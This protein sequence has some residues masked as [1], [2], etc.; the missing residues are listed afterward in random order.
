MDRFHSNVSRFVWNMAI[1]IYQYRYQYQYRNQY[2]Y[3]YIRF[4]WNMANA[5]TTAFGTGS[6]SATLPVTISLLEEKNEVGLAKDVFFMEDGLTTVETFSLPNMFMWNWWS[7]SNAC[8]KDCEWLSVSVHNMVGH[9]YL[10][11]MLIHSVISLL[12]CRH[13][14]HQRQ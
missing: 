13:S 5:F 8:L 6:S 4:I 1:S 7:W 9:V 10:I 11:Q 3:Q 12:F 2:Q 14:P